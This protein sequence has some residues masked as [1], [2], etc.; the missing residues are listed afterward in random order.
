MKKSLDSCQLS[1]VVPLYN[2]SESLRELYKQIR[3]AAQKSV[4]SYEVIFIDDGSD[5]SSFDI[6]QRLTEKHR[7]IK[8]ISF[9]KNFGKAAALSVGFSNSCGQYIITMDADLQD[10]P[11]E[12][13]NLIHKIEEGYDLV[14][15]WK[16][17]RHDRF[18][19]RITSKLFNFVT[20]RLSG[21]K[22]HDMNCGLKAYRREV[23]E[24]IKVYGQRHR[25]L[26]VLAHWQGFKVG[27]LVVNHRPRKY[28]KTK[29]GVARF[30]QGFF[31]LMTIMFLLRFQKRPL[32][33]F[34]F[35]GML[36]FVIGSIM[37]IYLAYRRIFFAD[38][39]S[40]RPIL[41]LAIT[42]VIVGIQV[43]SIGLL[44]EMLTE[45]RQ[46]HDSYS[47]KKKIGWPK[48]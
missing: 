20:G 36:S 48:K 29:Y 8:V 17:K 4:S 11:A 38:Y 2:E 1:V 22:I 43:V 25:F 40:R 34:G 37:S 33:L 13:P 14:S 31:D 6:L 26:P 35:V 27:E 10:D 9:R 30:A 19:K 5:D 15:G 32:H 47:I 7:E 45:S 21:I 41:F 39:L 44:G 16:K 46:E 12:I 24:E 42:L 23:V 18:I 3:E 28:G